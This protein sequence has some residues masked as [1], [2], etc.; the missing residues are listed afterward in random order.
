[1]CNCFRV[2]GSGFRGRPKLVHAG[3]SNKRD[4]E[5]LFTAEGTNSTDGS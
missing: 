3:A 5:K 1:L 4:G 2:Q